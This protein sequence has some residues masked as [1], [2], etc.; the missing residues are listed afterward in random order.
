MSK[1]RPGIFQ[2]KREVNRFL[3][4]QGFGYMFPYRQKLIMVGYAY[5]GKQYPFLEVLEGIANALLPQGARRSIIGA[6]F[7]SPE[8]WTSGESDPRALITRSESATVLRP[9]RETLYRTQIEFLLKE[10]STTGIGFAIMPVLPGQRR[11]V[12]ELCKRPSNGSFVFV[13]R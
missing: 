7:L 10:T 2:N 9:P 8:R 4:R 3:Q 1:L 12:F 11:P 13:E 5:S 6:L